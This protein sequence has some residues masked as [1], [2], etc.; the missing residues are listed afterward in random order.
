MVVGYDRSQ[1]ISSSSS[2]LVDLCSGNRRILTPGDGSESP[3]TRAPFADPYSGHE[4]RR[5][6]EYRP[7]SDGLF[8][9]RAN[10]TYAARQGMGVL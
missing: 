3:K 4:V 9:C 8:A 5:I 6:V 10:G 1:K 2:F 7:E